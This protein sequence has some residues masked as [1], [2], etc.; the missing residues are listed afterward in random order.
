M[1]EMDETN[2]MDLV[3]SILMFYICT[4]NSLLGEN[5]CVLKKCCIFA[6]CL[7][8]QTFFFDTRKV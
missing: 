5:N 6:L 2:E 1:D 8:T 7:L 3:I 4:G